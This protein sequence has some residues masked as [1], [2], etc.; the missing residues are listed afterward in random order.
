LVAL[1]CLPVEKEAHRRVGDA[2]SLGVRLE[3]FFCSLEVEN[4]PAR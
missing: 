2:L 1:D 4:Q 3:N